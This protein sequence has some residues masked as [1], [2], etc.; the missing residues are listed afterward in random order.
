MAQVFLIKEG[1]PHQATRPQPV[2][3]ET[4]TEKLTPFEKRYFDAPPDINPAQGPARSAD[5]YRHVI[6]KIDEAEIN[7]VFP[8]A[9]YYH[10][11][12]LTPDDCQRLFGMKG[13]PPH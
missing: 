3:I 11:P 13:T 5:E 8:D 12:H 9:G 1:S 4:V 2:S 7:A 10:I 6:V